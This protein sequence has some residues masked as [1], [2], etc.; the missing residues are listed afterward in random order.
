MNFAHET[1]LL[2][3]DEGLPIRATLTIPDRPCSLV[4]VI[5]GFKGFQEWGFFPWISEQL[6]SRGHAVCRF[7]MS[8]NGVAEDPNTFERLDLFAGDTYSI[9]LADLRRVMNELDDRAALGE[10]PRFLLGHSRGGAI[11]L[12]GG[13]IDS[14]LAGVIT[15][16]SIS[17][18]DRW[19]EA[20]K[21]EWRKSG[22]LEVLNQRTGQTMTLSTAVLDDYEANKSR[23]DVLRA[24]SELEMPLLIVHGS[25]D[26]SVPPAEAGAI[27]SNGR[28]ASVVLIQG[29]GH[30]FGAIHPLIHVPRPL[31]LAM[32]ATAAFI[33]GH[34]FRPALR[35]TVDPDHV[36][37]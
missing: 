2:E 28:D 31:Q 18:V 7:D 22:S 27:A 4:V 3:S 5:H 36:T 12:L 32:T 21:V 15:W 16:A 23:L 14:R 33:S 37:K 26:D 24:A 11:A 35:R 10:L 29:T 19:D 34:S 1:L 20:T 25:L 9:Q 8:R 30:T 6:A 13:A 17:T